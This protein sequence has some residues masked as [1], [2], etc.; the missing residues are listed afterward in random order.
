MSSTAL[1]ESIKIGFV[2]T[3]TTGAAIIGVDQKKAVDLAVEHI[4]GKMGSLDVKIVYEDD[5]FNPQ[6]GKQKT[7]KL[8]KSGDIDI[9]AGYIWSHVLLASAPVVLNANKILISANAG[10]SP[11]AASSAPAARCS[12]RSSRGVTSCPRRASRSLFAPRTRSPCVVRG[13]RRGGRNPKTTSAGER[14]ELR[15]LSLNPRV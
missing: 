13:A 11:L 3:L 7:E 14:D 2:T 9:V 6:K 4:G 5:E 1:A 12:S 15:R 8:I 10:P